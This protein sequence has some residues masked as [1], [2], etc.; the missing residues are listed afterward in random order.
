MKQLL[1]TTI[2]F[3][4][5]A[6]GAAAAELTAQSYASSIGT[7]DAMI[8]GAERFEADTEHDVTYN[9]IPSS[10][11]NDAVNAAAA[12]GDLPDV[13]MIDGPNVANYVWAGYLRP[14]NELVDPELLADMTSAMKKQGTYGPD[15]KLYCIGP[16]DAGLSILGNRA[17]LEKAGVRI[18]EGIDDA[19]TREEFED[20]LAKLAELEEVDAPLDMKLNYGVGEWMTYAFSPIVQSMGGDLIDRETWKADGTINSEASVAALEMVQGWNEK[21]WIVPGSA[22]DASFYGDKTSALS[23]IANWGVKPGQEG[24]GDDLL[25]LPMPDFGSGPVTALG[26]WC[27]TITRDAEDPQAAADLL[28]YLLAPETI[29]GMYEAGVYPSGRTSALSST[30]RYDAGGDLE[31]YQKQLDQIAIERPVHPAY[32]VIS[33]AFSQAFDDV[34]NGAD[35]QKALDAAA[36]KI[37]RDIEDN[38]GYP[39]FGG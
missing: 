19:W 2:A 27:W 34:L 26:S 15:G 38:A 18:P 28:E 17:Y 1:T 32:P 5:V 8:A 14:L 6:H 36:A 37:D 12:A 3:G 23:W 7:S 35:P 31:L 25:I 29:A 10:G 4:L 13:L 39:P 20:A 33:S 11:Y 24:L 30:P 16:V 22:G 21:G 9:A